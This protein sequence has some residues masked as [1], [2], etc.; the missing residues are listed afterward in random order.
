[1]KKQTIRKCLK[2]GIRTPHDRM[3]NSK[4]A[5]L[6]CLICGN[7]ANENNNQDE[8]TKMETKQT[9][10]IKEVETIIKTSRGRWRLFKIK[11][12][13]AKISF[14]D[15]KVLEACHNGEDF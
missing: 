2:C 6:V 13:K 1:M 4:E 15:F 5:P 9:L 10:T 12:P 11:Y 3:E 7:N 8:T 14:K